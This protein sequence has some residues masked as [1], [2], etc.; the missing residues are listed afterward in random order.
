MRKAYFLKFLIEFISGIFWT[1][2]VSSL[3]RTGFT[4]AD[5][6]L[7]MAGFYFAIAFF[8][9]PTGYVADRFGRRKSVLCGL[10]LVSLGFL[11][12]YLGT[13][14]AMNMAGAGVAGI[15]FTLISGAF[16]AWIYNL[17]QANEPLFDPTQF[18]LRFDA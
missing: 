10:S 7:V 13:G 11:L 6:A 15:G 3:I 4:L 16:T 8:E 12:L 2:N 18:F 14:K 9:I 1:A 17:A 5:S